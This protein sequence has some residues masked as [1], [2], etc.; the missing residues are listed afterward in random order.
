MDRAARRT[1]QKLAAMEK[2][3]KQ[4]YSRAH[5]EISEKW[6]AYVN[7]HQERAKPLYDAIQA[8][9]TPDEKKKAE[10]A[11]SRYVNNVI[12]DNQRYQDLTEQFAANL[13]NVNKTAQA[14]INGQL[15]EI[16]AINYNEIGSQIKKQVKGYSFDV[17]NQDVVKRLATENKTLLPYKTVDEKKTIRWNTKKVN[18]EVTQGIIQGDS[19]PDI[20]KRLRNVTEMNLASSVRNAR[21]TTTSAQNKGRIDSF[22]AAEEKGVILKKVW[23][24]TNDTRTRE[25]HLELDGQERD[26]D[27]PFENSLG[28]IMYPGDINADPA[29][30]YNCRCTMITKVMGF[31]RF[32]EDE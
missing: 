21:T 9:T 32:T 3:L 17:V 31:K 19:I 22:H 24:A 5:G 10:A 25:E 18:A 8:A 23:L 7:S 4:I 29:N 2:R 6:A 27:E 13:T 14:Y 1:D 20:A 11:F 12:R 26:I 15:P 28:P 16:Y 30:V